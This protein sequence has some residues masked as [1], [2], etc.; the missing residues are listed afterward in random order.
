LPLQRRHVDQRNPSPETAVW[1]IGP[2]RYSLVTSNS[3]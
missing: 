2:N 1:N 3:G